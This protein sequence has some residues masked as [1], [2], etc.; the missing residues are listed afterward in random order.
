MKLTMRRDKRYFRNQALFSILKSILY[1]IYCFLKFLDLNMLKI[2]S[3]FVKIS[4]PVT[5]VC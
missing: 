4:F 3:Q 1:R 5:T 2:V